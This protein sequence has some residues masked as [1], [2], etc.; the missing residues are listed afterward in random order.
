[1]PKAGATLTAEQLMEHCRDQ[2]AGYKCPKSVEFRDK[3][4][5]QSGAGKVL[6][7]DLREPYWIGFTK[8]VN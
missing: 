2:I 8:A 1:V 3:P 6:K 4:L 5:P 7:R